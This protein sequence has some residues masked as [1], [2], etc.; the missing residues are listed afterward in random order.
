MNLE[1]QFIISMY[2]R[3]YKLQINSHYKNTFT[4]CLNQNINA[5]FKVISITLFLILCNVAANLILL[6]Y[7]HIYFIKHARVF[8][9]YFANTLKMDVV[10]QNV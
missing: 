3:I 5:S 7:L 9:N 8:F 10:L 1:C 6:V 4:K 2:E